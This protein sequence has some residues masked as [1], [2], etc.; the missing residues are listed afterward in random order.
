LTLTQKTT[1]NIKGRNM[2]TIKCYRF[3]KDDLT[4]EKGEMSWKIGEWNK[5]NGK[6]VCC[7]NGLHAGLTPRDSLRNV[8]G[9]RWFISEA[10]GEIVNQ[11]NK[12]ASSE[13]RLVQEIP[14]IVLQIFAL[15][16][17]TDC[18]KSYE[19]KF[20]NDTRVSDCIKAAEDFL[21]GK[22]KMDDLNKKRQSASGAIA[23]A[24]CATGRA[25]AAAIAASSAAAAP[26]VAAWASA[27]AAAAY[28]AHTA[29]AAI[30]ASIATTDAFSAAHNVATTAAAAVVADTAAAYAHTAA[31]AGATAH[32]AAVAAARNVALPDIAADP[33]YSSYAAFSAYT[34][35]TFS[36]AQD[37]RLSEMINQ[38][39]AL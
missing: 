26:N 32:A 4:S 27:A 17:A 6:I 7:S 15:W 30:A 29:A 11:N 34:G 25:I 3:V 10:R 38:Y 12:F 13:M 1:L 2:T 31:A 28:A 33:Y 19:S 22:I 39:F 37:K 16:C 20:P 14:K 18:L 35:D 24:N 21:D 5:V 9:Q 23:A 8:Y 36:I